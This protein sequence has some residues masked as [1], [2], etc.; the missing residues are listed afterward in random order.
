MFSSVSLG[1]QAGC[2]PARS[3]E[4]LTSGDHLNTTPTWSRDGRRIYFG[5]DR[6]GVF[7]IW[8]IDL[9]AEPRAAGQV[10]FTGGYLAVESSDGNWLYYSKRRPSGLFRMPTRGGAEE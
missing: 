2:C 3:T 1:S 6:T 9:E 7:E 4:A 8:Q 10:T 5:S